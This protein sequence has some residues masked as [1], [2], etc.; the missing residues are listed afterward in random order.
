MREEE[1]LL[2]R[3]LARHEHDQ[4]VDA[5]T[6]TAGGGHAILQGTQEILVDEHRFVVALLA[7]AHLFDETLFLI[8]RVVQLRIG[9]GQFLTVDHQ[10]ETLGQCRI[11]AVFLGE[12]RHF[13]RIVGDKG[14]LDISTLAE[15][16]ENLVDKLAFTHRVVDF[17]I[18][19]LAYLADFFFALPVQVITRFFLDGLQDGQA[20]IGCLEAYGLSVHHAL[21][22]AVH[23]NAD[24]FEQ[25]FGKRHHPV[26]ILILYI[27]FHASELRIV[28][29]VHTLVAEV[30]AD[31]VHAFETAY[32]EAFQVKF[33]GDT[34]IQVDVERVVVGNERARAGSSRDG[35]QDR[36][37]HLRVACFVQGGTQRFQDGRT[38]QERFLHSTVDNQV[39]VT[40]AVAQFRVVER[41]IYLAVF[42][43]DDGQGLE[44]LGQNR[45][46]LRVHADFA[47]LSLE[48]KAFDTDKVTQVEQ[49]L[50]YGVV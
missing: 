49:F 32:D 4:T 36:C 24:A 40:L 11:T 16:A 37:L 12:R 33:C 50:E 3:G 27:K 18:Q 10:L 17:Q 21:R 14:R 6:D 28:A 22:A 45:Q 42:H 19:G 30:L 47:C 44:A 2:N 31:F 1:N 34:K 5:D 38:L 48:N 23:G 20:A 13:H 41:V 26:V 9:I 29:L 39:H 7:Q 15:L 8:Y 46:F 43:L 35:L 25:L